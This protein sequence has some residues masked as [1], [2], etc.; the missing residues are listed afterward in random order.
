MGS[1]ILPSPIFL[2]RNS[3]NFFSHALREQFVPGKFFIAL[4]LT[5][6]KST[7]WVF[8][9]WTLASS[10]PFFCSFFPS[11][12]F[13]PDLARAISGRRWSRAMPR[14]FG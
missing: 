4:L 10:L 5:K 7:D 3:T 13:F 2:P 9:T 12:F 1:G 11:C 8:S 6:L 14:S